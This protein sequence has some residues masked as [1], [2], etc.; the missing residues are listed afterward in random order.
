MPDNYTQVHNAFYRSLTIE[1]R[2]T[3]VK[4]YLNDLGYSEVLEFLM[5]AL[6]SR[7]EAQ[8]SQLYSLRACVENIQDKMGITL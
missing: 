5:D 2:N 1:E 4:R 6:N 3:L 7:F 8:Q